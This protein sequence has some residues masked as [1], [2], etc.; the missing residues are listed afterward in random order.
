MFITLFTHAVRAFFF[1][2]IS[3]FVP[4]CIFSLWYS[5]SNKHA[6]PKCAPAKKVKPDAFH[7][8][9]KNEQACDPPW[10]GGKRGCTHQVDR[11]A[12]V[13]VHQSH[14][15]VHQVTRREGQASSGAFCPACRCW[16]SDTSHLP[17]ENQPKWKIGCQNKI[18]Q[19][20]GIWEC[21]STYGWNDRDCGICFQWVGCRWLT[22]MA[23]EWLGWVLYFCK[24]LESF[25]SYKTKMKQAHTQKGWSWYKFLVKVHVTW[26]SR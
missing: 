9:T 3:F 5:A 13:A 21:W 24:C 23:A 1:F 6:H 22:R 17:E 7:G 4:F 19:I 15:A 14:Q 12:D 26:E 2:I 18:L 11:A 10:D 16:A 8:F 20:R 25:N